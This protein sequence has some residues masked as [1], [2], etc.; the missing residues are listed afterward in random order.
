MLQ[1]EMAQPAAVVALQELLVLQTLAA[2]LVVAQT[3]QL[4]QQAVQVLS[5]FVGLHPKQQ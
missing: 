1:V 4:Q 3:L 5:F 2:A